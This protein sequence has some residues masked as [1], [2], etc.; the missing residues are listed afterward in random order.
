MQPVMLVAD[1][2]VPARASPSLA[3][4]A[5]VPLLSASAEMG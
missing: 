3:L 1:S 4:V 5:G 2:R